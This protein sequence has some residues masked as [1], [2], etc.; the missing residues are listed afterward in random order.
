MQQLVASSS[1]SNEVG[2]L[3]RLGLKIFWSSI[4]M[5]VPAIVLEHFNRWMS[6]IHIL[7]SRPVPQVVLFCPKCQSYDVE[8]SFEIHSDLVPLRLTVSIHQ[9]S[10]TSFIAT[11]MNELTQY[12]ILILWNSWHQSIFRIK[13][14]SLKAIQPILRVHF[15]AQGLFTYGEF[16]V[17]ALLKIIE[18]QFQ[19]ESL[20]QLNRA[21]WIDIEAMRCCLWQLFGLWK[22]NSNSTILLTETDILSICSLW[23]TNIFRL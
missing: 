23:S 12:I 20:S 8:H 14:L 1:T 18:P 16:A 17:Q 5:D 6:L 2:E 7:I 4:Y 9:E 3:L 15:K 19:Y 21:S 13:W 11:W 10:L 22:K